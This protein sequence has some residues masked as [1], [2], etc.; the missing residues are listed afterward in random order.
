M[1]QARRWCSGAA[2][3]FMMPH[4]V[5]ADKHGHLWTTDVAAH[6]VA[7]WTAAGEKLLE[8]GVHMEP[9]HDEAHF[10]KPTQVRAA[11]LLP[12]PV[13]LSWWAHAC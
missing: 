8:L 3:S 12:A 9:G 5:T 4:M 1:L 6:T 11:L 13:H 10:C 2:G 7:K